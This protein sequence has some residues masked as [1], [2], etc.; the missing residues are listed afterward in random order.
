MDTQS[1][2]TSV[3]E[4]SKTLTA[5]PKTKSKKNAKPSSTENVSNTTNAGERLSPRTGKPV[6]K[7][8]KRNADGKIEEVKPVEKAEPKVEITPEKA[9]QTKSTKKAEKAPKVDKPLTDAPLIEVTEKGRKVIVDE[10]ELSNLRNIARFAR[11]LIIGA[12]RVGK[13]VG[14]GKSPKLDDTHEAQ[15]GSNVKML[16]KLLD[17][18]PK[19]NGEPGSDVPF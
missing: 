1:K 4:D 13:Y 18:Q 14:Y 6:R 8:V 11:D 3:K 2:S 12:D 19:A 15:E 7:Y 17:I 9:K 16:R 10:K 5:S